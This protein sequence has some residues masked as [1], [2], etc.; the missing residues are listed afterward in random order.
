MPIYNLRVV[1]STGAVLQS[2]STSSV[3]PLDYIPQS[4]DPETEVGTARDFERTELLT[5]TQ[6][7]ITESL[8]VAVL[9]S[10]TLARTVENALRA[11]FARAMHHQRHPED[12]AGPIYWEFELVAGEGYWRSEILAGSVQLDEGALGW[13][14]RGKAI[15]LV[16]MIE[17]WPFFEGPR[18]QVALTN[19][20]GTNTTAAL[21]IYNHDDGHTGHDSWVTVPAANVTGALP[22]RAEIEIANTASGFS[23]RAYDLYVGVQSWGDPTG[24]TPALE[25]EAATA[26][27]T[28][29]VP[30]NTDWSGGSAR[31]F[32]WSGTAE[33][34]LGRFALSSALLAAARG[35]YFRV[36]ARF[37]QNPPSDTW[38]R[39]SVQLFDVTTIT[40]GQQLLLATNQE[41]QDLGVFQ[42]PPYLPGETGLA[43]LSILL[44]GYS[45][46]GSSRSVVVDYLY[47]LPLQR[48]RHF[49]PRGY[50]LDSGTLVR[51]TVEGA[52]RSEGWA[53]GNV[54]HYI[55]YGEPLMLW[56]GRTQRIH[57]LHRAASGGAEPLRTLTVRLWHRP[58]RGA[59]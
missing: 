27:T 8:R 52:I 22:C 39:A 6:P 35:G 32:T 37:T 50:G 26:L 41:L 51:E 46:A 3:V 47:L 58:R 34:P 54:G 45:P 31:S 29:S 16:I 48:F 42:L 33:T 18:T 40:E 4:S 43:G 20:N 19:G 13:Q 28:S 10:T 17:R 1:D 36:F 30:N 55:G 53:G 49:R 56:P 59:L 7:N 9:D 5:V 15:A 24:F 12:A 25:G 38:L 57:I 21:T 44:T 11:A 23:S 14:W 2:L